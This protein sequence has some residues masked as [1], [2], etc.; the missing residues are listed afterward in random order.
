M[1]WGKG[2]AILYI[3][4]VLFIGF[5][6]YLS[7]TQQYD[8]VTEDYYAE[9]IN[10]QSKIDSKQKASQLTEELKVFLK[11]GSLVLEFPKEV[12]ITN[13]TV[14]CFRPSNK[15]KDFEVPL[16]LKKQKQ[17]IPLSKFVKGK[18]VVKT[19]W[20]SEKETFYNEQIVIIP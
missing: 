15:E 6:I 13:G 4:F 11:E 16:S 12:N 14:K 2:I 7:T 17:H 1:N 20:Q 10:Y 5:M 8:L 9:E 3:S 18:Y 19:N